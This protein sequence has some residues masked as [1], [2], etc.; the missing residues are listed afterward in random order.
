MDWGSG[1]WTVED[2][3]PVAD[4]A[5]ACDLPHLK[6]AESYI[7]SRR[8]DQEQRQAEIVRRQAQYEQQR[9]E[10]ERYATEDDER[11]RRTRTAML[12]SRIDPTAPYREEEWEANG[13]IYRVQTNAEL[14]DDIK[15]AFEKHV[16]ELTGDTT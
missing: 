8:R 16:A 3:L 13:L 15:T 11:R 10:M 7:E 4:L 6:E 9:A 14:T 12:T 5:R 1:F 2:I